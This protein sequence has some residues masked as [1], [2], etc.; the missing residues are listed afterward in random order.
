M[1]RFTP[2]L[3]GLAVLAAFQVPRAIHAHKQGIRGAEAVCEVLQR[4]GN[5]AEAIRVAERF[6]YTKHMAPIAEDAFKATIKN[7][8]PPRAAY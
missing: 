3:V 6:T 4:G 5:Q 8:Q 2:F 1:K 7:C